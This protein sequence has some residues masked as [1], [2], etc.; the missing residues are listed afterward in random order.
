MRLN[1]IVIS[2]IKK[3]VEIMG[4]S[5]DLNKYI[6]TYKRASLYERYKFDISMEK[7]IKINNE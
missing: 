7:A 5:D 1:D 3:Y 6:D 2:N 4:H